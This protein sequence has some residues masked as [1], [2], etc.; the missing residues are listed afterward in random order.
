MSEKLHDRIIDWDFGELPDVLELQRDGQTLV[1]YP[2]LVDHVTHCSIEVFDTPARAGAQ[3]RAGLRRLFRL[4]LKDQVKFLE[5]SLSSL[6]MTQ[7]RAATIAWLATALPS[8][9]ELREQIVTA[10]LDRTCLVLPL[11]TDRASFIERK[12]EARG[13]LNLI[14]Q[15]L[16]RARGSYRRT[17]R[18]NRAQASGTENI[19]APG[20]RR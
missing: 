10:A 1:G 15:E 14:A 2:A 9:E 13:K 18:N 12:E 11:P 7:V 8:F 5:R 20:S 19:S 3:H 16:A 17:S 6:Q 4:Q